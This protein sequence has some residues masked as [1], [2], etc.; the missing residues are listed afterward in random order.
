MTN[1]ERY[2]EAGTR[3][4]SG[5]YDE[6]TLRELREMLWKE[7]HPSFVGSVHDYNASAIVRQK[8]NEWGL[9]SE[10]EV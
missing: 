6:M 5:M 2:T 9:F 3:V 8:L 10:T 7:D 1:E 4:F